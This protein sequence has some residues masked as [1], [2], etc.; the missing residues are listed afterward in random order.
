LVTCGSA[1]YR[2]CCSRILPLCAVVLGSLL[3]FSVRLEAQGSSP[4]SHPG[5]SKPAGPMA[6]PLGSGEILR[7]DNSP[8]PFATI[9]GSL[10]ALPLNVSS[11]QL[12]DSEAC[13]SWTESG[14][15]SPTVSAARLA[16]PG[17]A[18]SEYQKGCG[19]YKDRHFGQAEQHLRK[20]IDEYP[21]YAAAWVVLG[22]VLDAQHKRDDARQ[23]CSKA[24]TLD[25]TYVA[26]YL[27][28][29][30][31]SATEADWKQVSSLAERAIALDPVNNP[32][33]LYYIADADV[34][35]DR[36]SPAESSALAAVHLDTWH[37]LPQLHL[38]LAQIY[39]AKGDTYAEVAQLREYLKVAPNSGDAAGARDTLAQLQQHPPDPPK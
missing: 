26:P 33:C 35:L 25:P 34:H 19:S 16:I 13:N 2:D 18:S 39:A 32:Y 36:L 8:D 12:I 27:C 38:L 1:G 24:V 6:E 9:N 20:A 21:Q 7:P 3:L 17:K 29:A 28:L 30:E 10:T 4:G 5:S 23:A 14:V 37:R 11:S 31:F 22:Q 15:H